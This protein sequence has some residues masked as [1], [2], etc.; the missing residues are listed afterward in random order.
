V[1]PAPRNVKVVRVI[2]CH[3]LEEA[4]LLLAPVHRRLELFQA[5]PAVARDP[6]LVR[7]ADVP[8]VPYRTARLP[9]DA[10]KVLVA[11]PVGGQCPRLHKLLY[12]FGAAL[13]VSHLA[14]EACAG[15]GVRA[16]AC[17]GGNHAAGEPL[18]AV[19]PLVVDGELGADDLTRVFEEVRPVNR[20]AVARSPHKVHL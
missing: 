12:R 14:A 11:V 10:D 18:V 19:V 4:P 8:V 13:Q 6:G 17:E 5:E 16:V 15:I 2:A 3:H 9:G 1:E 20:L 7:L